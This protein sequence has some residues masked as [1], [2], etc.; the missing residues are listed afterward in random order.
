MKKAWIPIVTLLLYLAMHIYFAVYAFTNF[1]LWIA[2]ATFLL[3]VVGDL[4]LCGFAIA[5]HNWLPFILLNVVSTLVFVSELV[6]KKEDE[7]L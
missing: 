6:V 5:L 3:P 4:M 1:K 7:N 2:L